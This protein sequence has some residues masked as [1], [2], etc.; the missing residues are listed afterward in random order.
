MPLLEPAPTTN[1]L[2]QKAAAEF[3]KAF[4]RAPVAAAYAP[5]RVNL[6]GEHTDYNLGFVLPIG[7]DRY[8]VAV[9]ALAPDAAVSRFRA[10]DVDSTVEID[11]REPVHAGTQFTDTAGRP[12]AWARYA[13]GVWEEIVAATGAQRQNLDLV[14]TSSVPLGG[15]LSS[16]ASLEVSLA[17][18]F[19]SLLNAE[20]SPIDRTRACQRAEHRYVGVPCGI[21]DMYTSVHAC[22]GKA[23]LIDCSDDTHECVPMPPVDAG[24]AV[25]L[26][27]NSNVRH[28]LA[29]GEY[30]KRAAACKDAARIL[31]YSSLREVNPYREPETLG[32]LPEQHLNYVRHVTEENVRTNLVASLLR[33][34]AE[35]QTTW[36][37]A[38]PAIGEQLVCSHESLRDQYA[39]SCPEL[40]SLVEIACDIP[41]VYGARM[42]GGGFGGCIVA[43]V[44]THM[45]DSVAT[46]L[47]V[48]YKQRHNKDATLYVTTAG[49]GAAPMPLQ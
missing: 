24:G 34:A 47:A 30:A 19:T 32:L 33:E 40:D 21:M 49:G 6:V 9:G 27:V 28:E 3:R 25:V 38:L 16:S 44:R 37:R 22:K 1:D 13:I 4:G 5:G 18:L 48:E 45:V 7:L 39:V 12:A 23:L 41:G 14:F 2:L 15:G 17:T 11:L 35:G 43:L 31:G 42:T 46:R 36:K 29:S 8:C 26:I 10:L 20:M